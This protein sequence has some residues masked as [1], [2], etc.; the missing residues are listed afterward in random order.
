[1]NE[2]LAADPDFSPEV[3]AD[4]YRFRPRN[5]WT[6]RFLAVL[7]GPS[8][9]HR[10]YCGKPASAVLMLFTVGGGLVW[11]IWDLFHLRAMVAASDARDR[12]R[13]AMGQP[14]RGMGFLPPQDKL[15]LNQTP[16]WAP[17][18]AG[19]GRVLG[20]VL[21]LGLIGLALGSVTGATGFYEPVVVLALFIVISLVAARIPGLTRIP[22]LNALV[23]WVH[24]LRLFYHS[25]DPGSLWLLAAR[26]IFGVFVAPWQP[27][28][29]AEVR[30][31]LQFG[32]IVVVLF[33]LW[34]V[35]E[36]LQGGGF[37]VGFGRLL[38]QFAQTLVFTYL[39]VAPASAIL[40]TQLLLARR[41]AVVW[42]LSAV[43]LGAIV[44]GLRLTT[45]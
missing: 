43:T 25:V 10:F 38:A 22:I 36:L 20:S 45:G 34:D 2:G 42:M 12:E 5:L 16:H 28:A 7:L 29:R 23:R 6:A 30:L 1:M 31:H 39:F 8:G 9:A 32:G 35:L 18:R 21:V 17:R 4:L 37:W 14:P 33:T 26:P 24:R 19:R 44:A 41:D 13:E 11:W 40:T 15:R 3:V 27:K